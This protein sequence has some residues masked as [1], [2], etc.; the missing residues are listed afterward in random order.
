MTAWHLAAIAAGVTLA[1]GVLMLLLYAVL[2][3]QARTLRTEMPLAR[4]EASVRDDV[5]RLMDELTRRADQI[6]RQ[7]NDRL[8]ALQQAMQQADEKLKRLESEPAG[9]KYRPVDD[10]AHSEILRLRRQ[11]L[12]LVEIARRVEMDVGEVEL[13][14]NLSQ[15]ASQN[16]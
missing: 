16:R 9:G 12:D 8:Q 2:V 7:L 15:A 5:R 6:D 3:R 10:P 13:V 14:V 4:A 11:G 1:L